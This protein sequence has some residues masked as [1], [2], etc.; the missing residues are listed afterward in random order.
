MSLSRGN[1]RRKGGTSWICRISNTTVVPTQDEHT[2][3]VPYV[4]S[5]GRRRRRRQKRQNHPMFQSSVS[6]RY[7][8]TRYHVSLVCHSFMLL[9]SF[10]SSILCSIA[11][12]SSYRA[13]WTTTVMFMMSFD[14]WTSRQSFFSNQSQI[15]CA[16]RG[17]VP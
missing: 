11:C 4:S 6:C 2:Q 5:C 3:L 12:Q 15:P 9:R 17:F 7:F 10:L 14:V 8:V 16:R 1:L 13:E